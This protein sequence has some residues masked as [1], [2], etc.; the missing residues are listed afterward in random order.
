MTG[1]A[2][3]LRQQLVDVAQQ[4]AAAA[5]DHALVD[6]VAGQLRR[7]LL[8][9]ATHRADDLLEGRLQRLRDLR[10][11]ERHGAR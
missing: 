10:A 11:A 4:R 2:G 6:D 9:H 1:H 5:H 8:E 7:S 3:D